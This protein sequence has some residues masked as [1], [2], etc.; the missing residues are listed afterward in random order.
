MLTEMSL[1]FDEELLE[2]LS[3][4]EIIFVNICV[5]GYHAGGY[6]ANYLDE[7]YNSLAYLKLFNYYISEMP[8]GVAKGRTGE[9]DTWIIRRLRER[10]F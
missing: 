4:E 1:C 2:V 8:Y 3:P 5:E 9:P 7:F 6:A 10:Q